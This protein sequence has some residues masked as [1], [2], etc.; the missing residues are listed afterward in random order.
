MC[1]AIEH[2]LVQMPDGTRVAFADCHRQPAAD[3]PVADAPDADAP[4][5]DAQVANAQPTA[6]SADA[7]AAADAQPAVTSAP[8]PAA[9]APDA[10]YL[11]WL[12]GILTLHQNLPPRGIQLPAIDDVDALIR[13]IK[14]P[15]QLTQTPLYVMGVSYDRRLVLA[16]LRRVLCCS[17]QPSEIH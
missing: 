1:T 3:A 14:D 9:N 17:D 6:E 13:D 16:S 10:A 8:T 5:A 2:T 12:E 7:P 11:P 15:A 4:V